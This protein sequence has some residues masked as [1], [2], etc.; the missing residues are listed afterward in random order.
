MLVSTFYTIWPQQL[1]QA[2]PVGAYGPLGPLRHWKSRLFFLGLDF[3]K[4]QDWR[5][6]KVPGNGAFTE[7]G[8]GR[9][10]GSASFKPWRGELLSWAL[11]VL[12]SLSE[13]GSNM[14]CK[15]ADCG[16]G[17]LSKA[18]MCAAA[19]GPD[20]KRA[21]SQVLGFTWLQMSEGSSFSEP[22]KP[23]LG[24]PW[25][26]PGSSRL[27]I[28]MAGSPPTWSPRLLPTCV[29]LE[30]FRAGKGDQMGPHSLSFQVLSPEPVQRLQALKIP[31]GK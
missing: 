15:H 31:D 2:R 30:N 4:R 24:E 18:A 13:H 29:L 27:L 26:R 8:E 23:T 17:R 25:M 16:L 19:L 20:L 22:G 10:A 21:P 7:E 14:L 1:V 5:C 11:A 6:W 28:I 3:V 12:R 9:W